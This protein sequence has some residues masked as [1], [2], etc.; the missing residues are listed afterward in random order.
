M[1]TEATETVETETTDAEATAVAAEVEEQEVADD[2]AAGLKTALQKER[3][4]R[5]DAEKREREATQKLADAD[6][7][8]DEK[9]LDAARREGETAG[10][11]KSNARLIAAEFRAAAEK[12]GLDPRTALKLADLAD[13]EV[14][15]D[16][17][18]DPVALTAAIDAVVTDHP[19]LVPSRFQ[20]TADQG[21]RGRDA[22]VP[23][24]TEEALNS[25]TPDQISEAR[26]AGRLNTLLGVPK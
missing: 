10:T 5:K 25:M 14:S 12:R 4:L 3:Q 6:K 13:L 11:A 17:E 15:G 21:A 8:P 22:T 9:A 20:G 18:I 19:S 2:P 26:K 24:L 7:S 16:G 1:T 23:Q